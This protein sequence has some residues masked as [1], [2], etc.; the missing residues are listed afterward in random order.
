MAAERCGEGVGVGMWSSASSA[1]FGRQ[2]L[3]FSQWNVQ[4][5]TRKQARKS[6]KPNSKVPSCRI[7]DKLELG[8]GIS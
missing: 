1:G 7:T 6:R 4:Q 3:V 8:I 5:V 2:R